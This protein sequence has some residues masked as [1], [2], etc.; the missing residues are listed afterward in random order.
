MSLYYDAAPLLVSSGDLGS[1]LKSKVFS[2]R[3]LKSP[4]KQVYALVTEAAKWSP[5]LVD[6]IEKSQLLQLER[7]SS[8]SAS[9]QSKIY[10]CEKDQKRALTLEQMVRIAGAESYVEIKTGQDFLR[11]DPNKSPWNAIGSLLL[12]PSCSGSGIVGRDE[13]LKCVLPR[14]DTSDAPANSSRKRKRKAKVEFPVVI[15]ELQEEV[16]ISEDESQDQLSTR[17]TALSTF[18]IKLLLHAF[19]FPKAR[20]VTY[21]TC[22]VYA[23]EN[24]YVVF[25]ALASP[26][27]TERGWRILRRGKQVSGMKAWEIRGNVQS[28]KTYDVN[29]DGDVDQIAEACIRCE[30]GTKEGTQGF[31]VAAFERD[32]KFEPKE[33][34]TDEEWEGF[35]DVESKG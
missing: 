23:E 12:D 1:S 15:G 6:V 28:C 33:R 27:A 24:E 5:V 7:K 8:R 9:P 26:L 31:F 16:P 32:D 21:S 14:R 19:Q 20:R 4:P 29:V 2:S 3:D 13:A 22:S 11:V 35:S 30:K 34:E 17:L 18:Q 25:K 10:A